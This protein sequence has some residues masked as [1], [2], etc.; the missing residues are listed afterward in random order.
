M[1]QCLTS[2]GRMEGGVPKMGRGGIWEAAGEEKAPQDRQFQVA[3]T[4]REGDLWSLRLSVE[5][6]AGQTGGL[7]NAGETQPPDEH[8]PLHSPWG[9][10]C[11]L[12]STRR[13]CAAL[14]Q[15]WGPCVLRCCLFSRSCGLPGASAAPNVTSERPAVGS[16]ILPAAWWWS[17]LEKPDPSPCPL[18]IAKPSIQVAGPTHLTVPRSWGHSHEC[19]V[20]GQAGPL[21]ALVPKHKP[22]Q[23]LTTF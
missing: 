5:H 17:S 16:E 11:M 3:R 14:K 9:V 7:A 23:L 19:S 1:C 4:R 21:R 2:C 12:V 18:G 8:M 22:A 13:S 15:M 10:G 6:T 20:W